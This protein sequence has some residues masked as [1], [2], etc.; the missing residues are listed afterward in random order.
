VKSYSFSHA[1]FKIYEARPNTS[2]EG[3]FSN[4]PFDRKDDHLSMVSI[5]PDSQDNANPLPDGEV[6]Y[7]A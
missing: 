4:Y 1:R 2:N 5:K 6:D 7:V 3:Y